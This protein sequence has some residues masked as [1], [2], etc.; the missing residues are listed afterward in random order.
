MWAAV[1][2]Y[3][4]S[5]INIVSY[6]VGVE[7][8]PKPT[9]YYLVTGSG[10][11]EGW[12]TAGIGANLIPIWSTEMSLGYTPESYGGTVVQLNWK[13]VFGYRFGKWKP[14]G[15]HKTLI[16]NQD[17]TFILL[18]SQYPEKYYPPTGM[19]NSIGVGIEYHLFSD[20][21]AYIE[22]ATLDYYMEAYARN[23]GYFEPH[24]VSTYGIGFKKNLDW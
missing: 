3:F 16:T 5:F 23:P 20:L 24:E 14:Y 12:V 4:L 15:F 13:N 22:V 7:Y 10:S 1:T 21:T 2:L 6:D 18:P 8:E 19:Y 11:Y 9:E 17:D